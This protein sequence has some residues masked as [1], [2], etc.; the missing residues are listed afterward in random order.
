MPRQQQLLGLAAQIQP[1]SYSLRG[2]E[3]YNWKVGNEGKKGDTA[4][5]INGTRGLLRA[6]AGNTGAE[7][8]VPPQVQLVPVGFAFHSAG[9]ISPWA[10]NSPLHDNE[11]HS[12]TS[13]SG[14]SKMALPPLP[15]PPY[16]SPCP[17]PPHLHLIMTHTSSPRSTV[18]LHSF[19]KNIFE[20]LE[21]KN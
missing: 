8:Q 16:P 3:I 19:L 10:L 13:C 5:H 17:T 2:L 7:T 6:A 9:W 21:T 11:V 15:T 1:P 18:I 14:I 20:S 4:Q 12:Y